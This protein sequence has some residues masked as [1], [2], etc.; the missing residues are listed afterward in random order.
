MPR[1]TKKVEF[2]GDTIEG[3][4]LLS[5]D[6]GLASSRKSPFHST[7]NAEKF[8]MTRFSARQSEEKESSLRIILYLVAVIVVGVGLALFVKSFVL[9]GEK[10]EGTPTDQ[11]QEQPEE[12]SLKVVTLNIAPKADDLAIKTTTAFA[13]SESV[14]VGNATLASTGI[15]LDTFVY[16]RY[17]TF[18]QSIFTFS[19]LAATKELPQIAVTFNKT[20][21]T[22]SIKFPTELKLATDLQTE[23]IINDI[24]T[25]LKYD[26]TTNTLNIKLREDSAYRVFVDN[27]RLILDVKTLAQIAKESTAST[28]TPT[29]TTPTPAPTPTPQAPTTNYDNDFSKEKQFIV[30]K[31]T[32]NS[33]GFDEIYFTDQYTNFQLAFGMKN[34][35][36]E[37]FIPNAEASLV[38]ENGVSYIDVTIKNL[39][40][41]VFTSDNIIDQSDSPVNLVAAN[42]VRA[43]LKSF[44][45]T[46]GIAKIR[47][48]LKNEATYRI[49]TDTTVSGLTQVFGIEISD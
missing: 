9:K 44:D 19:G 14:S 2:D 17:T 47:I 4:P 39:S 38:T 46:S 27:G 43:E 18:A 41:I 23:N 3:S 11:T 24:V 22:V 33:I 37:N 42:F 31:L 10:D 36:G 6:N 35:V 15:S 48:T 25:S 40:S 8:D 29:P 45:A 32:T 49:L 7:I 5:R 13:E 12:E 1:V 34:N 16:N 28:P 21:D 30:S 26:I 20:S